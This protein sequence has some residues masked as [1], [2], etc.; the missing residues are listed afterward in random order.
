MR[1][2]QS[3]SPEINEVIDHI[4]DNIS[5]RTHDEMANLL[6]TAAQT[7]PYSMTK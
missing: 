1:S 7:W 4:R 2:G 5:V 3:C 6:A